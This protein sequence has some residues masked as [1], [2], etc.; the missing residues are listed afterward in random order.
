[1]ACWK[2][3][4]EFIEWFENDLMRAG[5]PVLKETLQISEQNAQDL[6]KEHL[7]L[8]YNINSL[9][10]SIGATNVYNVI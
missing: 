9:Q 5:I 10:K 3:R 6:I 8:C 7:R 4:E 2:Q 1:M